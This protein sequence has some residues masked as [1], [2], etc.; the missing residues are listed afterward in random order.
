MLTNIS[1]A[2]KNIIEMIED[3][4]V[5]ALLQSLIQD[6]SDYPPGDT[7]GVINTL[8]GF[9]KDAGVDFEILAKKEH[10]PSLIA[11]FGTSRSEK[12]LVYHAHVDTVPAGDLEE[13]TKDPFDAEIEDGLIYGRGAGDDKGSVAA[14]IMAL[15]TL[16]RAN[17]PLNGTLQIA[18]VADEESGGDAGTRWLREQGK[19]SPDF[20]VVGEQ[21]NNRVA[22]AERVACGIDLTI[23]G[24]SA[25]G[26]MTWEGENAIIKMA[27]VIQW[28]KSQLLDQ[29]PEDKHPY[30]PPPTLN[31]GKITGG[32]QWSIVPAKCKIEMDRRLLPG[33]TRAEA[34]EEIRQLLDKYH[35]EVEEIRYELFTTGDVAPNINTPADDPFVELS[36]KTLSDICGEQRELTGYVQTSDGRW[37]ADDGIPIIIFGP[38]NPEVGHSAD[39]YVSQEQLTEAAQFYTLLAMRQ[40]GTQS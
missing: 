29:F 19:I 8:K 28:L 23:F 11:S 36:N 22:I 4:E 37:F 38:S 25:H 32:I 6:R 21:T 40:L 1:D 35:D 3:E 2:E 24:E 34:M 7:R 14:Q 16:A 17:V 12:R 31:I 5:A 30:L 18:A 15:V 13:W 27:G 39:E 20:L 10:Q 9:I 26:A 33:E